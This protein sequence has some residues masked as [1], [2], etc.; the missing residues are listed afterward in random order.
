MARKKK[1]KMRRIGDPK[2]S[3]EKKINEKNKEEDAI[4]K[5]SRRKDSRIPDSRVSY[6]TRYLIQEAGYHV[7]HIT[8][9]KFRMLKY[10]T[11]EERERMNSQTINVNLDYSCLRNLGIVRNYFQKKHNLT[12]RE[13]ELLLF[14]YGMQLWSQHDY[15]KFPHSFTTRKIKS[16]FDRGFIEPIF[17]DYSFDSK[18][19]VYRLTSRSK[20][21]IR[22]FYQY[23]HEEKPIPE[24]SGLNPLFRMDASSRDLAKAKSIALLNQKIMGNEEKTKQHIKV[25]KALR[26]NAK[27]TTDETRNKYKDIIDRINKR[28]RLE[29]KK[30]NLGKI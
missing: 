18:K 13:L 4:R 23:L 7:K 26:E 1:R 5:R 15:Y 6:E 29:E 14:L 19:Q 2:P 11:K 25:E 21:L 12:F 30:K 27:Q 20:C 9:N 24:S 22:N 3:E 28:N 8:K 17:E 10:R 16:L